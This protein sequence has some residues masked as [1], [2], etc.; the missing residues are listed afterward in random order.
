MKNSIILILILDIINCTSTNNNEIS[1]SELK[2]MVDEKKFELAKKNLSDFIETNKKNAEAYNLLGI[3]FFELNQFKE[4][5]SNFTIALESENNYKYYYNRGNVRRELN[6]LN[7]ALE[8]FN[9][10][11]LLNPNEADI[12]NNR[13]NL[14][15]RMKKYNLALRDFIKVSINTAV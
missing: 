7:I 1:L 8:D 4:A 14:Y 9:K 12:Y 13:G 3:C 10:A 5:E 11:I 6:Q 2:K 15:Y